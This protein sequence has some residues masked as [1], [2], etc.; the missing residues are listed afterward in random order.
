MAL[1]EDF[2]LELKERN[3]IE[4]VV[5]SYVSIKKGGR[6]PKAL[7]PF[8]NEKTPS[9]TLYPENGSFYCFGC[10]I[11]PTDRKSRLHRCGQIFGR[12]GG[13]DGAS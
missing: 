2:L 10:G 13:N 5:S 11:Y 12:K 1:N 3:P 9:F 4:D 7:C 6:N 8:H